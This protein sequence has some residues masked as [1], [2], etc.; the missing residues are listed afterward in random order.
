MPRY[1]TN[2]PSERVLRFHPD[3][4]VAFRQQPL[5]ELIFFSLKQMNSSVLVSCSEVPLKGNGG[6]WNR[7]ELTL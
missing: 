6:S 2:R 7:G 4:N 5:I 1:N 3:L